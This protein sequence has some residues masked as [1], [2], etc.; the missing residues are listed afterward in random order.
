MS[1]T[2]FPR[3]DQYEV[4]DDDYDDIDEDQYLPRKERAKFAGAT[5]VVSLDKR[6]KTGGKKHQQDTK[7]KRTVDMHNI[8]R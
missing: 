3:G 4:F 5:V 8:N 7:Q 6:N 1:S 2:A